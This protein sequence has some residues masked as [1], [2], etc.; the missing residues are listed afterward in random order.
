MRLQ[1]GAGA[2]IAAQRRQGR[3]VA[4]SEG[5]GMA[6]PAAVYRRDD[7]LGLAHGLGDCAQGSRCDEGHVR[8]GDQPAV[9][10]G[11]L[12]HAPGQ[13][14]THA[15]F[16]MGAD[17]HPEARSFQQPREV[18]IRSIDH[19]QGAGEGGDQVAGRRQRH[20]GAVGQAMQ[21]LVAAEAGRTAGGKEDGLHRL[22]VSAQDRS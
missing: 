3:A 20:G 15:F 17:A 16:R 4:A 7:V 14:G 13:A 19:G 6:A 5:H 10:L 9:G 18:D 21:Q 2:A 11:G 22:A 8:Q 1:Q 12:R